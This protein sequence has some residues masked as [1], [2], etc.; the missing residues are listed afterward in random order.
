MIQDLCAAVSTDP[1]A[2]H[3]YGVIWADTENIGDDIQTLAGL[4]FLAKKNIKHVKLVNRE[5][6]SEYSG[7]PL[8]LLMNGWFMHTLSKFPPPENITPLFISFHCASEKLISDNCA[9]F[10]RHAPIG[11]RDTAT[12]NLFHTYD[13]PAYFT[14]CLTLYFDPVEKKGKTIYA[15][16]INSCPY[17]PHVDA[18]LEEYPGCIPIKHDFFDKSIINDPLE[19]LTKAARL[20]FLYQHAGLVITTRLHCVLPCR[21]FGTN[22]KFIHSRLFQDPRFSGLHDVIGG[23]EN[24]ENAEEMISREIV[25][26]YADFFD[27][28]TMMTNVSLP[29]SYG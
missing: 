26:K 2:E 29:R 16:D 17:I 8:I 25:N 23:A 18:S 14:G 6:L 22:V 4:N 21:A 5:K 7:A 24:L 12:M 19:R 13:I 20:L 11:C 3:R 28:I 15:V 1:T 9:Y 27:K 10:R